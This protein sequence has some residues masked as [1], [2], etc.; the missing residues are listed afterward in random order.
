MRKL[1]LK[2][3]LVLT[4]CIYL[5][6]QSMAWGMLGHRI[7]GQIA[8][9]YLT[10]TARQQIQRILGTESLAIAST[11]AD[12]IKS[13]STFRYL[14][15]WHYTDFAA[16]ITYNEMVAELKKDTSANAYT[17]L[18]FLIR[19]LKKKSGSKEQKKLYLRLLIHIAGDVHQPLHVS[20]EGTSG[21]NSVKVNWFSEASNLHRVWDEHLIEYQQLSYTEYAAAINHT[22][23]TQRK[24]W[25]K[26]P[27]S[28]WLYES[29]TL[30]QQL[31]NEITTPTPR[32]G[33]EYNF[34]HV[35]QLNDQLLKGGVRLAGILNEIFK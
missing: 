11:W 19:E 18:N 30:S 9:S 21:G 2:I 3:A 7:V 23:A 29:Y 17:K 25:Q 13:D 34:K 28:Q 20:P 12:F 24:A 22:T 35:Q 33:Y 8:D 15:N 14:N 32:L 10:A 1:I 26:Q 6:L 4:L 27:M 31:H 16:N 5:P